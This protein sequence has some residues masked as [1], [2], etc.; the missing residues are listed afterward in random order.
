MMHLRAWL[1]L[2]WLSFRRLLWS[3]STLMVWFPLVVFGVTVWRYELGRTIDLGWAFNYFSGRLIF[4]GFAS[5]VLP[6]CVVAF[7]ATSI[8]GDRE[9]R[10]L[11]FILIRPIS[12]PAILAAK[13]VATLPLTLGLIAVSFA[14][15]C[16]LAGDVG[17]VAFPLYLGPLL[18]LAAAYGAL[19]LMF[20][21]LFRHATIAALI[22]TVFFETMLG[23]A[24]GIV[25]R[26]AINYYARSWMHS[27]GM[28]EGLRRDLFESIDVASAQWALL[29]WTV[30]PLL[31]AAVVFARREYRDLS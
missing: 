31:I 14:L 9:D 30:V 24:P 3:R 12:R 18:A 27:V 1:M 8:G 28:P 22:Y 26:L 7:S 29:T 16:R 10:T 25:K 23:N 13:W 4:F 15:A 11:L 17:R 2:L 21:V 5:V 20:S 6:L 19:F